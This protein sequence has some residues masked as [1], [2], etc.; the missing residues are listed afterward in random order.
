MVEIIMSCNTFKNQLPL[1]VD[2]LTTNYNTENSTH[3]QYAK[4]VTKWE[5]G[6]VT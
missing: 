1:I 5:G 3:E 6:G 2:S 4:S